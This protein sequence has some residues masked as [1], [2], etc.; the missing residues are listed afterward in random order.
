M[1]SDGH[2]VRTTVRTSRRMNREGPWV[3]VG[4]EN[5]KESVFN[6]ENKG[7]LIYISGEIK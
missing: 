7:I 1:K 5:N 4:E 3:T 6:I 2:T